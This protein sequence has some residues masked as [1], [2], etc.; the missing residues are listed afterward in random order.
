MNAN[1]MMKHMFNCEN[2]INRLTAMCK[3]KDFLHSEKHFEFKFANSLAKVNGVKVN[4]VKFI[5]TDENWTIV[6]GRIKKVKM[7]G[8]SIPEYEAVQEY[9]EI[10][11]NQVKAIFEQTTGYFT[12]L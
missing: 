7:F 6:F 12:S 5:K 1:E 9:N 2:P 10:W 8:V 11:E 3:A 4:H